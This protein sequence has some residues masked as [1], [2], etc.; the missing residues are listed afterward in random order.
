MNVIQV[1]YDKLRPKNAWCPYSKKD[2]LVL[3]RVQMRAKNWARE[4]R[5][6][7]SSRMFQNNQW[8]YHSKLA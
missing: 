5:E 3:K 1:C 8:L 6:R 7:G 4:E 2:I